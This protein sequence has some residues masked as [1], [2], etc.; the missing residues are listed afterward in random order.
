VFQSVTQGLNDLL[1]LLLAWLCEERTE[2]L[3]E[4]SLHRRPGSLVRGCR[5]GRGRWKNV[6][7]TLNSAHVSLLLD[8]ILRG[9]RSEFSRIRRRCRAF[10]S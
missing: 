9:S 4:D 6:D 8:P 5:R 10:F 2:R 1:W 3:S 7:V